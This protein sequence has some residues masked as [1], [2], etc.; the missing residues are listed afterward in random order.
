MLAQNKNLNPNFL[1]N[2]PQ[3]GGRRG[4]LVL[5]MAAIPSIQER[6][7]PFLP[8]IVSI[9]SAKLKTDRGADGQKSMDFARLVQKKNGKNRKKTCPKAWKY[10]NDMLH[11]P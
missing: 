9:K 10:K 11:L 5:P 3:K 6:N 1:K 8:H 7:V 2:S 4:L